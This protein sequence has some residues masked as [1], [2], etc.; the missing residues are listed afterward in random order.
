MW[1]RKFF[2]AGFFKNFPHKIKLDQIKLVLLL[3]M[4]IIIKIQWSFVEM[5][6]LEYPMIKV[7]AAVPDVVRL[8][9][10]YD[11]LFFFQKSLLSH[12]A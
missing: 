9:N 7:T 5:V 11:F 3:Y 12:L 8:K 4:L 6:L 10:I 2:S 1:T